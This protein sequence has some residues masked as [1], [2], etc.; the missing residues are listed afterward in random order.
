MRSTMSEDT[1]SCEEQSVTLKRKALDWR[2]NKIV[3]WDT[4]EERVTLKS[5]P[6]WEHLGEQSVHW[7]EK[8]HTE[9]TSV[10]LKRKQGCQRLG[11]KALHCREKRYIGEKT[12][13]STPLLCNVFF[14]FLQ[15]NDLSESAAKVVTCR[16][17]LTFV[18]T[19]LRMWNR[20]MQH[21]CLLISS[22][23]LCLRNSHV[24]NKSSKQSCGEKKGTRV[25][26]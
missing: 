25:S 12:R 7:A 21:M 11:E 22:S 24:E 17:R 8:R 2:G 18:H 9:E 26:A 16:C 4:L 14:C 1:L 6:G 3:K 20:N 5:K 10:T 13:F 23:W 15:S 19:R